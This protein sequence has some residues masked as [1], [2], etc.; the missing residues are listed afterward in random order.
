LQN[1]FQ[2]EFEFVNSVTTATGYNAIS[3]TEMDFL[4]K[5]GKHR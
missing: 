5:Y 1:K 4:V 3:E 2:Y